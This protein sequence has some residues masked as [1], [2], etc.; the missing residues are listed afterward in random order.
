MKNYR[1]IFC[2]LLSYLSGFLFAQNDKT[3]IKE[4]SYLLIDFSFE[5]DAVFMGRHDSI[6]AP[7]LL[8]SVGYYDKSGFFADATLSYLTRS[9]ENRIDLFLATAGYRY[10]SK[11]WSGMISGT[12]Y[13]FNSDSYS[14]QSEI[15]GDISATIGYNMKLLKVS[16][17]A[18]SYYN[19]NGSPDIFAGLQLDRSFYMLDNNLEIKPVF[20]I[21]GGSQYFYQE[22][23]RNN[24]LGNR[25]GK[26]KF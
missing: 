10:E 20:T 5:S 24:R 8:P 7:Y 21:N 11:K 9:E 16:L 23:Y 4:K 17:N 14:V 2:L 12:K 18:A 13:F 26:N 19:S 22:Y 25:K 3:K 15:E 6:T 1:F